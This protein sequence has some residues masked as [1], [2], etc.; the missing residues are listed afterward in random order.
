MHISVSGA[1]F[2]K[3][4]ASTP[5]CCPSR[6]TILT[7]KYPHNTATHTNRKDGNCNGEAW[8]DGPEKEGYATFLQ[9][10]RFG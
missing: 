5:V 4:F 6:A 9:V 2:T 10:I 8:R 1:E 7:G 3:A